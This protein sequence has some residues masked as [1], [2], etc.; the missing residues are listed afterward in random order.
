VG[1]TLAL[2]HEWAVIAAEPETNPAA[3]V[4]AEQLAYVLYTSG[5][6][7]Q[8]KGVMLTQGNAGN[9]V[10]WARNEFGAAEL[11]QVV[12]GR[13]VCLDLSVFEWWAP[14]SVGGA[15]VLVANAL[16]LPQVQTAVTLVNTVPSVLAELLRGDYRLPASV[17]T[18]NLAGE[19]LSEALVA[20]VY[21]A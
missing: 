7:G 15:V 1:Q 10:Q 21:E 11:Q 3:V 2:D 14:W 13:S 8:P 12:A 5:S 4:E 20:R 17:V 9:L 18:V 6:T 16:A 19:A